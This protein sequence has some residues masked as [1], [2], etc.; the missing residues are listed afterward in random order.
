MVDGYLDVGGDSD[1]I[2]EW[3]EF[4]FQ[5]LH[6]NY[7]GLGVVKFDAVDSSE[8][9]FQVLLDHSFI[10]GSTQNLQEILIP[11]EIEPREYISFLLQ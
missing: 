6:G 3:H 11:D 5:R 10:R 2:V 8:E 4:S 9:F 7:F 1:R